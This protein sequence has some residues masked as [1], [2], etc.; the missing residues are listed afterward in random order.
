MLSIPLKNLEDKLTSDS[1]LRIHR[2]FIINLYNI[3][4]VTD[5]YVIIAGKSI[6]VSRSYKEDLRRRIQ[7]I[8]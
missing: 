1:L 8:R 5:N 7:L 2:S 3:D 4:E 6:P